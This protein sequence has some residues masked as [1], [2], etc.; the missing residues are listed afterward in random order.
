MA[1]YWSIKISIIV[2]SKSSIHQF[3]SSNKEQ[4]KMEGIS[5]HIL[6]GTGISNCPCI[7]KYSLILWYKQI[8]IPFLWFVCNFSIGAKKTTR[9]LDVGCNLAYFGHISTH[10]SCLAFLQDVVLTLLCWGESSVS[11]LLGILR[12]VPSMRLVE[13]LISGGILSGL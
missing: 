10:M 1:T 2:I 6:F 9:T 8:I 5:Y 12:A 7:S 3:L 4:A 13:H 11:T